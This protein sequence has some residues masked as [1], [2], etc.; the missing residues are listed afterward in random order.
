[1]KADIG[2]FE[3]DLKFAAYCARVVL[4]SLYTI[5]ISVLS[6]VLL[7]NKL[8]QTLK[9]Y[10]NYEHEMRILVIIHAW[11]RHDTIVIEWM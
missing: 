5:L 3:S 2:W 10:V 6:Y 4:F 9:K 7:V 11:T 8:F 1:M